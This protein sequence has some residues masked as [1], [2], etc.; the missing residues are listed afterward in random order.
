MLMTALWVVSWGILRLIEAISPWFLG[1]LARELRF[2]MN[3]YFILGWAVL[4][5]A[6]YQGGRCALVPFIHS[7]SVKLARK[8]L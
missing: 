5:V 8:S 1:M 2:V 4:L 7:L 6:A 3:L